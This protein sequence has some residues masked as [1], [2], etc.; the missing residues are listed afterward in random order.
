M[1]TRILLF[2][3]ALA[4]LGFAQAPDRPNIGL[5]LWSGEYVDTD[6][7]GIPDTPSYLI[8]WDGE[9]GRTY[10][11]QMSF[12]MVNWF[13]TPAISTGQNG[14]MFQGVATTADRQFFRLV[15]TDLGYSGNVEEADFDGDGLSNA[16]DIASG[17]N[18]LLGDTDGDGFTDQQEVA[19]GSDGNNAAS[20]PAVV[21][22]VLSGDDQT[23]AAGEPL[24]Q[25]LRVRVLQAGL[26]KAGSPVL[27][28]SPSGEGEFGL[29][30]T[31]G[32]EATLQTNA[33]GVVET[34]FVTGHSTGAGTITVAS[35]AAGA[36]SP[37]TITYDV[38]ASS[39]A[40]W[41]GG[42]GES[43]NSWANFFKLQRRVASGRYESESGEVDHVSVPFVFEWDGSAWVSE[44]DGLGF[45][46]SQASG[47]TEPLPER[48]EG[49]V[50]FSDG[51]SQ[52]VSSASAMTQAVTTYGGKGPDIG[53][54][55]A[56]TASGIETAST[57]FITVSSSNIT[58]PGA[59]SD[60]PEGTPEGH[61]QTVQVGGE[62]QSENY[63][64]TTMS[65]GE[66]RLK[67][68]DFAQP[69]ETVE[70]TFLV[71]RETKAAGATSFTTDSASVTT[72]TLEPTQAQSASIAADP[73]PAGNNVVK[74]VKIQGIQVLQP[75]VAVVGQTPGPEATS[76][77]RLCR[78]RDAFGNS[79]QAFDPAF[80]ATDPDRV[81]ITFPADMVDPGQMQVEVIVNGISGVPGVTSDSSVLPLSAGPNGLE[82]PPI[83]F[84]ADGEDDTSFNGNGS[85]DQTLVASPQA[86]ISVKFR[87]KGQAADITRKVASIARPRRTV[88]V[89][90]HR[91][92]QS[93]QAD[94][95]QEVEI[96]RQFDYVRMFYRQVWIELKM[97]GGVQNHQ[98]PAAIWNLA[99]GETKVL[100]GN[101]R[102]PVGATP[103]NMTIMEY[104]QSLSGS[105]TTKHL[106]WLSGISQYIGRGIEDGSTHSGEAA[107]LNSNTALV[108]MYMS[109]VGRTLVGHELGH[110]LGL[111][112]PLPA[113]NRPQRLMYPS[114]TP[115]RGDQ[116][117]AKRFY[118][119]EPL[120]P[121]Q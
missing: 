35:S 58:E 107:A 9:S 93:G 64:T 26:P 77:I 40:G 21:V 106:Y 105:S 71:T 121:N 103:S 55:E 54:N 25:S 110:C 112:H 34:W 109:E 97:S 75:K 83:I 79:F 47:Y 12:D 1:T 30:G 3:T 76:S 86:T 78:W 13:F 60:P 69:T 43:T 115:W 42:G 119:L 102:T 44:G 45:L 82:T 88:T 98:Y 7:D 36:G 114:L 16:A 116:L 59:P 28:T 65:R 96:L 118:Y 48:K 117:D 81:V 90:L 62:T 100:D 92:S 94:A 74:R 4:G 66:F 20:V 68:A 50:S 84:V 23:A 73:Q 32:P 87:P 18:P 80:I 51:T 46:W 41:S 37:A 91:F 63:E 95:A 11:M 120:F 85:G 31:G 49:S 57:S 29:D 27:F 38:I 72:L 2:W 111:E 67:W 56:V 24:W 22:E 61:R 39:G 6:D 17:L 99:T 33:S 15:H 19:Y 10:F 101:A 89:A 104:L 113:S 70:M 8:T 14:M 53:W 108:T 52:G 5:E